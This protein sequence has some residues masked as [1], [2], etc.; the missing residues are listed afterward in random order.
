MRQIAQVK[1]VEEETAPPKPRIVYVLCPAYS[2]STLFS[3]ALGEQPGVLNLGEVSALEHDYADTTRC[4]CGSLLNDCPFWSRIRSA[5][6]SET[7]ARPPLARFALDN[8]SSWHRMDVDSGFRKALYMGFGLSPG[9]VYGQALVDE[10]RE[11]NEHLFSAVLRASPGTRMMVDASKSALRL[12]VLLQ[13]PRLETFCIFLRRSPWAIAASRLKRIRRKDR[14]S[15]FASAL[16]TGVQ[17]RIRERRMKAV[18]EAVPIDRRLEVGW[19]EFML[20]P[21]RVMEEV[22]R[23]LGVSKPSLMRLECGLLSTA[24]QH[25]YVGNRWLFKTGN[26][27][28][29]IQHKDDIESLSGAEK[30]ALRLTLGKPQPEA[31]AVRHDRA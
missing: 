24:G 31:R 28:V 19:E 5:L 18:F 30:L 29:R 21:G 22:L 17:Q 25:L 26:K 9:L 15:R 20:S 6:E 7:Q 12:E 11:R 3:I 13:S 23:F 2:G 8:R 10:Y 4:L 1:Q 16:K 27:Q 14:G